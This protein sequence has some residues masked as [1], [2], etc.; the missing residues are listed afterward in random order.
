MERAAGAREETEQLGVVLQAKRGQ[1]GT[2]FRRPEFAK[3]GARVGNGSLVAGRLQLLVPPPGPASAA[4]RGA[5]QSA[6]G[7]SRASA[8]TSCLGPGAD[9][10][11]DQGRIQTSNA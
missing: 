3:E 11:P 1:Y 7:S 6:P 10:A 8:A 9:L 5:R 2:E 4:H